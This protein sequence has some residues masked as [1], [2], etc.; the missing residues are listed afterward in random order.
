MGSSSFACSSQG[1]RWAQLREVVD[2]LIAAGHWT[3]GD[4]EIL[5]DSRGH[6]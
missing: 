1:P 4:P 5:P 6:H 2:R 3:P